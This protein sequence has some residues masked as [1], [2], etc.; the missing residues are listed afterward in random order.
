MLHQESQG[1]MRVPRGSASLL[2]SPGRGIQPPGSLKRDSRG[3]SE[4]AAGNPGFP[5]PAL[6]T[7]RTF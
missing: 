7:F 1:S 5:R 2:S 3:L 6:V 4:V